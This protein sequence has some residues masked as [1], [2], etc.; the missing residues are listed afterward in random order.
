MG[1]S[2]QPDSRPPGRGSLG[3]SLLEQASQAAMGQPKEWTPL[4]GGQKWPRINC[5]SPRIHGS[6]RI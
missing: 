5:P 4:S 2:P 1:S 6:F 3:S